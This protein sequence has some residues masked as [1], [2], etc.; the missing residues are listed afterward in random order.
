MTKQLTSLLKA[1][2]SSYFIVTKICWSASL[3]PLPPQRLAHGED[4]PA[5][6]IQSPPGSALKSSSLIT[7]ATPPRLSQSISSL[8]GL[9]PRMIFSSTPRIASS[10][11]TSLSDK[12]KP[13]I[14]SPQHSGLYQP[15][16]PGARKA[17]S[18]RR[19]LISMMR[20][21]I[22]GPRR[23][24]ADQREALATHARCG[25]PRRGEQSR[26]DRPRCRPHPLRRGR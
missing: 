9:G 20:L 16:H 8:S 24:Y 13:S 14:V 7:S 17:R 19:P 23:V 12:P 10:R 2:F 21:R 3:P 22:S 25:A 1:T 4:P 26:T 18:A 15:D 5:P 11:R 6:G